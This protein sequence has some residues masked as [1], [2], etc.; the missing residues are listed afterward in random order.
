M[1]TRADNYV[2]ELFNTLAQC[3]NPN[4]AFS[5]W[6]PLTPPDTITEEFHHTTKLDAW[7]SF[8]P[9][10]DQIVDVYWERTYHEGDDP[11]DSRVEVTRVMWRNTGADD[12]PGSVD[13]TELLK[14]VMDLQDLL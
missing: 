4:T 11:D 2:S 6:T 8:V 13:V 7:L 14:C 10:D 5:G 3:F 12:I 9:V 1:T